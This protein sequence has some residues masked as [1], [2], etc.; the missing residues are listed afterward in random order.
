MNGKKVVFVG[1]LNLDIGASSSD[2]SGLGDTKDFA[3]G[4][5]GVSLGGAS[6]NVFRS[7]RALSDLYGEKYDAV[8]VTDIGLPPESGEFEGPDQYMFAHFAH[9]MALD[10]LKES[11]LECVDLSE[12]RRG[13]GVAVS[14]I[15]AW[16]GGRHIFK[17]EEPLASKFNDVSGYVPPELRAAIH[18]ADLVFLDPARP[19]TPATAAALC[20]EMGIC[21]L[22]DYGMKEVYEG[23]QRTAVE[24]ILGHADIIVVPGDAVVPGMQNGVKDP[25]RLFKML[26]SNSYRAGT[27]IMSDGTQP[28]Q[29]LDDG[30]VQQIDVVPV[31]NPINVSGIGD[32]RDGALMFFLVN[33][34]DREVALR[35]A[36]EVAALRIQYP[37]EEWTEHFLDHVKNNPLFAK[38]IEAIRLATGRE[39]NVHVDLQVFDTG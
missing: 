28:V 17:Q 13:A 21:M 19:W 35:K 31:D 27:V 20:E 8:L 36:M 4:G 26:C 33:G 30:Q 24:R 14:L 3:T 11:G 5:M 15:S 6:F 12:G 38:D 39:E 1:K 9:N 22:T 34:D 37:G 7:F 29:L 10:L 16:F 25:D 18:G 32:T 2:I 23:T